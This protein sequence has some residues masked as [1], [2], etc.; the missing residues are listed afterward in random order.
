MP[1]QRGTANGKPGYKYGDSGKVY[2]YKPGDEASRERAREK[3]ASQ[4]RAIEMSRHN[5]PMKKDKK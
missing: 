5:V 4:G 3:A 1:I 2:T